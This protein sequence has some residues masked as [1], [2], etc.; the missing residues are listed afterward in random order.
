M[1]TA[2]YTGQGSMQLQR[3]ACISGHAVC[4]AAHLQLCL[5]PIATEFWETQLPAAW[6][7]SAELPYMTATHARAL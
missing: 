5:P 6:Y 7:G 2:T 3:Q 4:C 1:P